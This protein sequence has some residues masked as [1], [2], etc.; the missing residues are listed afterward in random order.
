[1]SSL[2]LHV[3]LFMLDHTVIIHHLNDILFKLHIIMIMIF[4]GLKHISLQVQKTA[5]NIKLART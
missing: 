5:E 1:M 2:K 3:K 4:E